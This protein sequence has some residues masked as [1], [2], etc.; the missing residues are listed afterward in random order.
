MKRYLEKLDLID[1]IDPY[2]SSTDLL[3]CRCAIPSVSLI[4]I[5]SFFVNRTHFYSE[6]QMLSYKALDSYNI[7]ISGWVHSVKAAKIKENVIVVGKVSIFPSYLLSVHFNE[8]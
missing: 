3:K 8:Y 4:H 1:Q 2:S 5:F 7:F 6:E